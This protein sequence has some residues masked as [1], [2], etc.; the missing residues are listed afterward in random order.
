MIRPISV[1]LFFLSSNRLHKLRISKCF[2][3]STHVFHKDLL[4]LHEISLAPQELL[5]VLLSD[6]LLGIGVYSP[7]RQFAK[8]D[9]EVDDPLNQNHY[10]LPGGVQSVWIV[11]YDV[12]SHQLSLVFGLPLAQ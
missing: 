1:L 3:Q 4:G 11:A 12:V 5:Q 10:L 9:G 6:G 8:V 7:D 2:F